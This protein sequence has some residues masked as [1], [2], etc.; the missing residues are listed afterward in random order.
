[1]SIGFRA[2]QIGRLTLRT[3]GYALCSRCDLPA[4][5]FKD[6]GNKIEKSVGSMHQH[7]RRRNASHLRNSRP[8]LS[9]VVA[10]AE[11]Q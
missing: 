4:M 2:L 7:D 9:V 8:V 3:H 6:I 10:R 11:L 5:S 1:M